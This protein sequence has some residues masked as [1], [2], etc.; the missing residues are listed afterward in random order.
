MNVRLPIELIQEAQK[1][2]WIG[3]LAYYARL[4]HHRSHF[5]N[6]SYSTVSK[7]LRCSKSTLKRNLDI[8]RHKNLAFFRNGNLC[9]VGEY[10]LKELY[11]A[12][13]TVFIQSRHKKEKVC[14]QAKLI[15]KNLKNQ[16]HH[17][18]R[19]AD[20]KLLTE[21]FDI[22]NKTELKRL[23][24]LR[25]LLKDKKMH[26]FYQ[27]LSVYG[28]GQ[29]L[30]RHFMTGYRTQK[31]MVDEGLIKVRKRFIEYECSKED[32]FIGARKTGAI[33]IYSK[34]D[35]GHILVPIASSVEAV[36]PVNSR[37]VSSIYQK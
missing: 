36:K 23:Y 20:H 31:R 35:K 13:H 16:K 5:Y 24:R 7:L 17:I 21:N 34:F 11:K 29:I 19:L 10:K 14:L 4:K 9:L 33:P 37:R 15:E 28:F 25:F 30:S 32:L 18:D 22:L 3:S 8:L 1:E 2:R 12:K 6:F 26:K 27:C